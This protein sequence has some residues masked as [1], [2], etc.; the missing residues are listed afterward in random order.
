[1]DHLLF[2]ADGRPEA[3]GAI[4]LRLL[5][6]TGGKEL[7][8]EALLVHPVMLFCFELLFVIVLAGLAADTV[9]DT[10]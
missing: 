1:M 4:Y 8:Q 3:L 7:L 5:F 6:V 10:V 2:L 9:V